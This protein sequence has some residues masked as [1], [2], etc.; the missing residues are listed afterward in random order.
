MDT[1]NQ[2]P[3]EQFT[4]ANT[5]AESTYVHGGQRP[6][7]NPPKG[8][9]EDVSAPIADELNE[10][11]VDSKLTAQDGATTIADP[12]TAESDA[13]RKDLER[14]RADAVT[15][16]DKALEARKAHTDAVQTAHNATRDRTLAVQEEVSTRERDGAMPGTPAFARRQAQLQEIIGQTHEVDKPHADRIRDIASSLHA[17]SPGGIEEAQR[18]LMAIAADME[19]KSEAA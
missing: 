15:E 2:R 1:T 3:D 7:E 19:P 6:L 9:G 17:R 8:A 11:H 4:E 13:E 14:Q 5:G 12:S 10:M 18:E 16:Q